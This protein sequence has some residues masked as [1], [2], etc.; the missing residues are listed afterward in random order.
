MQMRICSLVLGCSAI[1]PI[2]DYE[3]ALIE[4]FHTGTSFAEM[5]TSISDGEIF[6]G[7]CDAGG[8]SS[9]LRS[10]CNLRDIITY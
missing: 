4:K 9:L 2:A 8:D 1:F 3:M 10:I 6:R 5:W 7:A